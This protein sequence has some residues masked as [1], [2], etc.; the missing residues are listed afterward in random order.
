MSVQRTKVTRLNSLSLEQTLGSVST[1]LPSTP[2]TVAEPK[3]SGHLEGTLFEEVPLDKFSDLINSQLEQSLRY[4]SICEAVRWNEGVTHTYDESSASGAFE[5]CA[6]RLRDCTVN[7]ELLCERSQLEVEEVLGLSE[8]DLSFLLSSHPSS[9][10]TSLQPLKVE[11]ADVGEKEGAEKETKKSGAGGK[12]SSNNKKKIGKVTSS[13]KKP[14]T[15]KSKAQKGAAVTEANTTILSSEQTPEEDD[16]FIDRDS[17]KK[18]TREEVATAQT[19]NL[20]S[21]EEGSIPAAEG[22]PGLDGNVKKGKKQ[23]QQKKKQDEEARKRLEEIKR[24]G[25]EISFNQSLESYLS[26]CVSIREA[27][28]NFCNCFYCC[29][30]FTMITSVIFISNSSLNILFVFFNSSYYYCDCFFLLLLL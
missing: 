26:V 20:S 24:R 14:T 21:T 22:S 16:M 13:K 7:E 1:A 9:G 8:M 5:T 2:T 29:Y 17:Y 25:R 12:K 6:N 11:P 10:M 4:P 30:C 28:C 27:F 3:L 18:L 15:K 19:D 23:Q